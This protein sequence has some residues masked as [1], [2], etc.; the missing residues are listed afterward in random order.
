MKFEID[1]DISDWA[2]HVAMDADGTWHEFD[3]KPVLY[4]N[5]W[6]G[7]KHA[8]IMVARLFT[9]PNPTKNWKEQCFEIVRE[10]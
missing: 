6:E 5:E 10:S 8:I 7:E 3:C 2:T 1:V 9:D 4:D